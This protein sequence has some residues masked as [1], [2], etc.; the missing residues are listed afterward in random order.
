M[1]AG[2]TSHLVEPELQLLGHKGAVNSCAFSPDGTRLAAGCA[3]G[4][5]YIWTVFDE[6]PQ[7]IELIPLHKNQIIQCVWTPDSTKICTASADNTGIVFDMVDGVK[8][9]TLRHS[10]YVNS[11]AT[12]SD[13]IATPPLV[14]TGSDDTTAKLWDL[15][16][17]RAV[18]VFRH[19]FPVTAVALAPDAHTVFTACID[20]KIRAFDL[21]GAMSAQARLRNAV[22]A[23]LA[24]EEEEGGEPDVSALT[25]PVYVLE[26][27]SGAITGMSVNADG[28][29]LASTSTD[30]T[31]RVW[32]ARR[33]V[34][35]ERLATRGRQL[36]TLSGFA[37]DPTRSLMVQCA[38]S[39]DGAY[40]ASGSSDNYACVWSS[41]TGEL[42][43]QLGGHKGPVVAVAF[44][45]TE[46]IIA[47]ASY[48]RTIFLSEY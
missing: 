33:F 42:K 30:G 3:D 41:L 7:N 8:L 19:D 20:E 23:R 10:S 14:L 31:V 32:D 39:A 24:G 1:P 48:D 21:R 6:P 12:A 9:K 28:S 44:H 40:V 34:T 16:L 47:S 46:P 45:P 11:V 27:H 5:V 26:G 2:R 13:T 36:T 22:A 18:A 17:K 15:R 4:G 29:A 43:Q 38:F 25:N 35:A 37:H